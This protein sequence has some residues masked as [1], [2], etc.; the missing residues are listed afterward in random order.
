MERTNDN[1]IMLPTVD[2]CFKELMQN[3]KVR[4]GFI[5]ALLKISPDEIKETNLLPTI[6]RKESKDDKMG[7]LDVR[8]VM[9]KGMQLDLEMQV[10]YFAHW[11]KRTLFYLSKMYTEQI[12]TG[13]PYE[14]L[15]KCIHVSILDFICFPN[16]KECYRTIHLRDDKT[17]EVYTDVFEIQILELKKLPDEVKDGENII[18]WMRF[19]SGKEREEFKDMA[20][21]DEY[22]DEAYNTLLKLSAD[23][24][25]RLEYEAREKALRDYNSQMSSAQKMGLEL[26]I[27]QG[28]EQGIEQGATLKLI[29][30]VCKK[31]SK[32]LSIPE[33]ADML[34]E[35]EGTIQ[36]IYDV[37]VKYAPD[38]D[39]DKIAEELIS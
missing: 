29:R 21:T 39:V 22:L 7:I 33:I 36:K 4:K 15:Q 12:N 34:E 1:F 2:F 27:K 25:K 32:N 19:F 38:Y 24:Q 23:K 5:A 20:K 10:A 8:V 26:G 13:E 9:D 11:D 31:M 28:I 18:K 3:P 14:K 17:G 30:Q 6:L 35:D 37:A 16:D